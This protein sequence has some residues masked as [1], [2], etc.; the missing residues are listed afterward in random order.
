MA[1]VV[2]HDGI[3]F[4]SVRVSDEF[5]TA[6]TELEHCEKLVERKE[7]RRHQS[8]GEYCVADDK[9]DVVAEFERRQIVDILNQ[10]LNRLTDRQ[11]NVVVSRAVYKM[12]FREIGGKLG[13]NKMVAR[14]HFLR[15]IKKLKKL[16][17]N[18]VSN[19]LCRGY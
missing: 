1:V 14:K 13:I 7:T 5:A 18:R 15:A 10:A 8:L 2:V 4:V 17:Q 19:D 6:Y 16:L 12:S 9:A 11:R 3:T